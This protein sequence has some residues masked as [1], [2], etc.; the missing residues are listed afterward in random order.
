MRQSESGR[1]S[2]APT[3]SGNL[4]RQP[5]AATGPK[6]TAPFYG[7]APW[8]ALI[9]SIIAERGRL[10]EARDCRTIDRGASGRIYGDHVRELKDG[11]APLDASNVQL[12]C[13]SC[14]R[15]KTLLV[16]KKRKAKPFKEWNGWRGLV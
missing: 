10:C 3:S 8:K 13:A 16:A 12:L 4:E 9:S 15:S 1:R 5:R 7:S 11:G 2:R 6:L 14:H